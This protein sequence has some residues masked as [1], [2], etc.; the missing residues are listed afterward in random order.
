VWN[1]KESGHSHDCTGL[2]ISVE[3]VGRFFTGEAERDHSGVSVFGGELGHAVDH[4]GRA[5]PVD[6]DLVMDLDAMS[7]SGLL[8]GSIDVGESVVERPPETVR[9][10]LGADHRFAV[11]HTVGGLV[12]DH[13]VD[14]SRQVVWGS[15]E[16]GDLAVSVD[17]ASQSLVLAEVGCAEVVAVG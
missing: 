14:Y 17:E 8:K 1:D 2:P 4:F 9:V 15:D 6:A 7:E 12:G 11:E 5:C 10:Q 13:F 3:T 16:I